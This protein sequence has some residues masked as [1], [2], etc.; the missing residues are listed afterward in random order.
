[1]ATEQ[2]KPQVAKAPKESFDERTAKTRLWESEEASTEAADDT[3]E[4]GDVE[5]TKPLGKMN[6]EELLAIAE[7]EEVTLE[8][9]AVKKD[10][11][12]AIEEARTPTEE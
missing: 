8:E 2:R 9:G 3:S 4:G 7:A 11:V 5:Q 1:M 12:A 6:K 10:I